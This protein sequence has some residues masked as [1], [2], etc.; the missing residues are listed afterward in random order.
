MNFMKALRDS[1]T[2]NN[3]QLCVGLDPDMAKFPSHLQGDIK[4]IFAFNKAIIDATADCVCCYKPQIAYYA[5]VG[6]E[7]ELKMSIDYIHKTYP[8]IPVILDAKRNDIGSTADMYAREAFTRYEADALTVNP[9]MGSDTLESFLKFKDKGVVVL[10]KTS[11]PGSADFQ[12]LLINGKP[13][14][15]IVAEKA[16]NEWNKNGN[17]CIVV[18][19]THP[20]EMNIIRA[21]APN[22]TFL[23]PGIGAQGGDI[24]SVMKNGSDASGGGLIINSSRAIIHADSSSDFAQKARDA[25]IKQRDAINAAKA[26]R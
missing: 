22:V 4:H 14:Y 15:Q 24:I 25:A 1:S 13:L 8:G 9:Y 6:A 11:N 3:S 20:D 19:A 7:D 2:K 5:A 12:N 17:V 26:A 16:Q 21:A 18:G 23:V 10:C